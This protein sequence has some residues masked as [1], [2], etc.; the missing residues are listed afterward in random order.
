MDM[1]SIAGLNFQTRRLASGNEVS[2]RCLALH[3][4][5]A[6]SVSLERR[7]Y[8]VDTPSSKSSK[9][10]CDSVCLIKLLLLLQASWAGTRRFTLVTA[11]VLALN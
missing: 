11:M 3:R 8:Y 6:K 1:V 10:R 9:P 5:I 2:R 4:V 7:R